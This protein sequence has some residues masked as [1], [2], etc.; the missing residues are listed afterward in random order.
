MMAA[1]PT[2]LNYKIHMGHG[3][4]RN[5]S[6]NRSIGV[7]GRS[8]QLHCK[9]SARKGYQH[10]PPQQGRI[11]QKSY[12]EHVE[13]SRSSTVWRLGV[14]L[15]NE[16]TPAATLW[17]DGQTPTSRRTTTSIGTDLSEK[18]MTHWEDARLVENR[19]GFTLSREPR[20]GSTASQLQNGF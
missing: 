19:A 16:V 5:P 10:R 18:P 12:I 8:L 3:Q 15:R 13:T 20:R 11:C 2:L 14:P 7:L 4:C 6:S 1:C 17:H 9:S